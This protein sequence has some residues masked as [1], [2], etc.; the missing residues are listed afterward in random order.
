MVK[1]VVEI[2]GVLAFVCEIGIILTSKKKRIFIYNTIANLLN[3]IQYYIVHAYSGLLSILV[4]FIRNYVFS[5]YDSKK[6]KTPIIWFF[7]IVVFLIAAQYASYDGIVSIIPFITTSLYTYSVWQNN[8]LKF[9]ELHIIIY[10]LNI[11]YYLSYGIMVNFITNIFFLL[12]TLIDLK[13][14][15]KKS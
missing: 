4:T 13:K 15:R 1:L 2:L 12:L 8:M 11:V 9:K 14:A 5:Y 6:K 3:A 10:S 7:L